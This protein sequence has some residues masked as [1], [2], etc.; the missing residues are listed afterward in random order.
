MSYKQKD[1]ARMAGV[2]RTTVSAVINN[3]D[4]V[5]D[6]TK[7]KVLKV[8]EETG[9]R[10]NAAARSLVQAKTHC[11]AVCF[12]D[13]T[14]IT[15]PPFALI[16]N[17]ILDVTNA[18][19]FNLMLNTTQIREGMNDLNMMR[20]VDEGRIDGAIIYDDRVNDD[21]LLK[22]HNTGFPIVLINRKIIS[23]DII[24]SVC[25]DFQKG[26]EL[27]T[28]HLIQL[29]HKRIALVAPLLGW[30]MTRE[31][32]KGYKKALSQAGLPYDKRLVIEQKCLINNTNLPNEYY[33][34]SVLKLNP[35]TT[36]II[37]NDDMTAY[38]IMKFMMAKGYNIPQDISI[39]GYNGIPEYID[40]KPSFTTVCIHNKDIG[41]QSAEIL[42]KIINGE[43]H[44]PK[45][46][47]ISPELLIQES[48]GHAP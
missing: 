42:L 32:I 41:R 36:A 37:F 47:T 31:R 10:P 3:Y 13:T 18:R 38:K 28:E 46:I 43:R 20:P 14:Y 2:S 9:Y 29:G 19:G 48:T 21:I 26:V 11:I 8:I 6:S 17:G 44:I 4:W 12:Y 1:I 16:V 33:Y 35:P 15:G 7:N 24:P 25:T 34:D 5:N 45:N 22:L 30:F 23:N 40:I 27:A 39:I